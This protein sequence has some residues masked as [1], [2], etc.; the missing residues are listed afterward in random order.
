[1]RKAQ[2][3]LEEHRRQAWEKYQQGIR[4]TD[5]QLQ[6]MEEQYKFARTSW[7]VLVQE[8][9]EDYVMKGRMHLYNKAEEE[10]VA[11]RQQRIGDLGRSG[12]FA[13]A[14]TGALCECSA[15]VV[16]IE[17]SWVMEEKE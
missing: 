1:M 2:R 7:K 16:L 13:G 12:L 17:P 5:Q 10:W 9:L 3:E 11:R 15:R 4:I 14:L 8:E 6:Q